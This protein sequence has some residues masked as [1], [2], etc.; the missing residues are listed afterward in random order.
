MPF[1]DRTIEYMLI[2]SPNKSETKYLSNFFDRYKITHL[3]V[4]DKTLS[5]LVSEPVLSKKIQ[6]KVVE[7]SPISKLMELSI[8]NTNIHILTDLNSIKKTTS[9]PVLL[10][11][12]ISKYLFINNTTNLKKKNLDQILQL[13]EVQ[14]NL[15]L[16]ALNYLGPYNN[17]S[18]DIEKLADIPQ[19]V[20]NLASSSTNQSRTGIYSDLQKAENAN[21]VFVQDEDK[22]FYLTK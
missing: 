16:L 2:T 8:L 9:S 5:Y 13:N 15:K 19:I 7:L 14:S 11:E 22:V 17:A 18:I 10:R 21:I 6:T 3:V 1:F 12:G 4:T 20:I